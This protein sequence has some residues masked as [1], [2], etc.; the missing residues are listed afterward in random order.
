MLQSTTSFT[1]SVLQALVL[2]VLAEV[3]FVGKTT[4][5]VANVVDGVH[6]YVRQWTGL[7]DVIVRVRVGVDEH[8]LTHV[9]LVTAPMADS[10]CGA[11]R[12]PELWPSA[13]HGQSTA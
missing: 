2:Q 3:V 5:L 9:P 6:A 10:C 8:A 4:A 12:V 11:R 7:V 13:R 1:H